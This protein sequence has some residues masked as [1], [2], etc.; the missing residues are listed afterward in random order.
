MVKT[1]VRGT[2]LSIL[3]DKPGEIHNCIQD[4]IISIENKALDKGE[5]EVLVTGSLYLVGGVLRL[6]NFQE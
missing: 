1:L 6:L 2:I 3:Q 5:V 4:A